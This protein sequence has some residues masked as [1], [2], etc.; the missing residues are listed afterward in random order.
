VR[1]QARV[2]VPRRFTQPVREIL[3]LQPRLE[4]R[5]GRRA[6]RL[7]EHP[8]FRAAYDFLMLRAEAGEVAG[9]IADWWTR[10]QTLE[11][12]ARLSEVAKIATT[13][14]RSPGSGRRR[15]RR[16]KTPTA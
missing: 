8:R 6:L 14:S 7:L 13:G 5:D 11:P 2:A 3:G 16:R 1:Q 12:D 10:L 9:E 15:R 4:R